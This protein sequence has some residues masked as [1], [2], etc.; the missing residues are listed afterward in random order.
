LL[1]ALVLAA[2]CTSA[3]AHRQPSASPRTTALVVQ[4]P[5]TTSGGVKFSGAVRLPPGYSNGLVTS[6]GLTGQRRPDPDRGAPQLVVRVTGT[7]WV[8]KRPGRVWIPGLGASCPDCVVLDPVRLGK[9]GSQWVVTVRDADAMLIDAWPVSRG[10]V[11][12]PQGGQLPIADDVDG[13]NPQVVDVDALKA[14]A[15]RR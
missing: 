4:P 2:G 13:G 8:G 9:K 5:T 15:G 3:P 14:R 6:Q 10:K 1:L 7:A 12:I 11:G